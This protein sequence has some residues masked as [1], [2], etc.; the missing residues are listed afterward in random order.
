M[1]IMRYSNGPLHNSNPTTV[2]AHKILFGVHAQ[3]S[4]I[5]KLPINRPCSCHVNLA[6]D[7]PT[8]PHPIPYGIHNKIGFLG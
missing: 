5:K 6:W 3:V 1:N 7:W 8:P 2:I 4:Y